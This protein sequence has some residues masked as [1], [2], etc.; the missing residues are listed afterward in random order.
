MSKGESVYNKLAFNG[1]VLTH[2][3]WRGERGKVS[4][5]TNKDHIMDIL[6]YNLDRGD[7]NDDFPS[8][9]VFALAM[10]RDGSESKAVHDLAG[11]LL[12]SVTDEEE[13]WPYR[14]KISYD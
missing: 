2:D 14:S 13:G 12:W 10:M 1:F 7:R 5:F 6:R 9:R 3:Q 11:N 8:P 4:T